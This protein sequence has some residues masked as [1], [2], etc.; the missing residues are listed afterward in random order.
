MTITT[1]NNDVDAPAKTF[2]GIGRG[3]VG[4]DGPDGPGVADPDDHGRRNGADGSATV[5]SG[6]IGPGRAG[7]ADPDDHGRWC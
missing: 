3:D 7:V 4:A 5:K 2:D 1:E 6:P